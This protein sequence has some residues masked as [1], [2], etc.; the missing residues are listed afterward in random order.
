MCFY[1]GE[2]RPQWLIL[3]CYCNSVSQEL[4]SHAS[5]VLHAAFT[6]VGKKQSRRRTWR[7]VDIVQ[8]CKGVVATGADARVKRNRLVTH[9]FIHIQQAAA[10]PQ[11]GA[12]WSV[13]GWF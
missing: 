1:F 12:V 2:K 8:K 5:I 3:L 9:K 10:S 13:S 6:F 11:E 7:D 4:C